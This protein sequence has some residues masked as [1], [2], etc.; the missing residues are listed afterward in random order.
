MLTEKQKEAEVRKWIGISHGLTVDLGGKNCTL[1]KEYDATDEDGWHNCMNADQIEHCPVAKE[2]GM[3]DCA[4]T[5]YGKWLKHRIT[6]ENKITH[7][8]RGTAVCM[9]C[10]VLALIEMHYVYKC[11][12]K[13]LGFNRHRV[14]TR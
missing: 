1:C 3:N 14:A 10:R 9:E 7:E 5:P 13:H 6:T 12:D 2:S 8:V 11:I 4:Y